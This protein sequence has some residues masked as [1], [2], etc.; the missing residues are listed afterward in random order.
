MPSSSK[1]LEQRLEA[2]EALEQQ[3]KKRN[4]AQDQRDAAQD[5]R[6]AAQER[7]LGKVTAVLG[8]QDVQP[9]YQARVGGWLSILSY[10]ILGVQYT[11][12][13]CLLVPFQGDGEDSRGHH[14]KKYA[15]VNIAVHV[16]GALNAAAV[17]CVVYFVLGR[18]DLVAGLSAYVAWFVA[19]AALTAGSQLAQLRAGADYSAARDAFDA[20][21]FRA[22]GVAVDKLTDS[23]VSA[24]L[25]YLVALVPAIVVG[26]LVRWFTVPRYAADCSSHWTNS[27]A[28]VSNCIAADGVCCKVLV[29]PFDYFTFTGFLTGNVIAAYKVVQFGA[30][31]LLAKAKADGDVEGGTHGGREFSLKSG[32]TRSTSGGDS[33]DLAQDSSS[34]V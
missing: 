28:G 4:A 13:S 6:D 14:S 5:Q 33:L 27:T 17:A 22:F 3:Q 24:P 10:V 19:T 7:L 20:K 9:A 18:T 16:S 30:M 32:R 23:N 31:C 26:F 25:Y 21:L 29:E 34:V 12:W 15:A 11:P 2:L 1:T 8:A